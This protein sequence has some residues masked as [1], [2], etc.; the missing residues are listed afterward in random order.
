VMTYALEVKAM[1]Q[2]AREL[3]S[4]RIHCNPS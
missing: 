3:D 2:L 1:H 4:R